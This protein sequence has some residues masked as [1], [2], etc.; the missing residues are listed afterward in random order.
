MKSYADFFSKLTYQTMEQENVRYYYDGY[1]LKRDK[2]MST[3]LVQEANLR[4]QFQGPTSNNI[5]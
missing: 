3:R 5:L 4:L 2:A 1:N